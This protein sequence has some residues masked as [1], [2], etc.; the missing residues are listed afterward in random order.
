MPHYDFA[1]NPNNARSSSFVNAAPIHPRRTFSSKLPS[2]TIRRFATCGGAFRPPAHRLQDSG[3]HEHPTLSSPDQAPSGN[4][5]LLFIRVDDFDEALPRA[6]AP[7]S[8]LEQVPQ[9][10]P[11]TGTSEFALRDL[12]GYYVMV[13]ALA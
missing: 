7:V 10:N 12:D 13:G 6:R 8:E 1:P 11:A 4:G 9:V 3:T 5:L 2:S